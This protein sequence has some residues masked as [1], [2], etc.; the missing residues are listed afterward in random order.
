MTWRFPD[1][2]ADAHLLWHVA[3]WAYL[4]GLAGVPLLAASA[5]ALLQ[6]ESLALLTIGVILG[7]PHGA[8]DHLVPGWL[9][10]SG[11]SQGLRLV[12][13]YVVAAVLAPLPTIGVLVAVSAYHF[14]DGE[15]EATAQRAHRARDRVDSSIGWAT[16]VA[17]LAVP[18]LADPR[19]V[20]LLARAVLGTSLPLPSG[21][22]RTLLLVA[23]I[24]SIVAVAAV[25]ARERR[26]F[27]ALDLSHLGLVS[28]AVTPGVIFA[29]AFALGHALCHIVR[30]ADLRRRADV[31]GG[32]RSAARGVKSRRDQ[33]VGPLRRGQT[34][35]MIASAPCSR[36]GL[37]R[38]C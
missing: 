33:V 27:S 9:N 13:P 23:S 18:A 35:A 12:A 25:A 21:A 6:R 17:M 32:R 15:A 8:F 36:P 37:L 24:L 22:M 38:V 20:E 28:L 7:V 3:T 11:R 34:V 31:R 4:L 30:L 2:A 16:S 19:L 1:V 29:V 26:W 14:A 10:G 5:P